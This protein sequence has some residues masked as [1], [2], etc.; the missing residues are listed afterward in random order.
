MQL[1]F[2]TKNAMKVLK[3]A[4]FIGASAAI[5][6]AISQSTGTEFGP[7]TPIINLALVAAREALKTRE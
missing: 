3:A 5:D 4:L 2:N 6:F 7:L 1:S